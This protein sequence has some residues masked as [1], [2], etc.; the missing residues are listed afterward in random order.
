MFN[1]VGESRPTMQLARQAARFSQGWARDAA[2]E[3]GKLAAETLVDAVQP[4]AGPII[5]EHRAAG[6]AVVLAT[7]TPYDLIKPLA[8]ALGLD[9]VVATRY[10][11][12]DGRYDG[13]IDGEFVWGK[14]KLDAV[15]E[16]ADEHD[17]SLPDSYAY[18]DSWFDVPLLSAVGHP[19]A[20]N[21]DPRLMMRARCSA[22]RS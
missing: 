21:P 3:A 19:F 14:G 15:K 12:R 9:D 2:Q 18:S 22:G 7:T 1:I 13:T 5:E 17:V 6:R 4:F 10:G 8:D 11:V 16:W 20:V